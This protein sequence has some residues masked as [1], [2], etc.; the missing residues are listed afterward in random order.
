ME[1]TKKIRLDEV[2]LMRTILALLI[3][4]MHSFTC[5]DGSW[6]QPVGYVDVPLYKW[7]SRTSFA[8]TL[9][10]FVFISGYLFAFQR[11]T[12]NRTGGGYWFDY[13]Q[14]KEVDSAEY[15]F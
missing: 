4:F 8:F 10:A 3:V 11:I 1:P 5:Y 13:Q 2:T 12:L 9:E 15:H 14:V 6:S 7:L